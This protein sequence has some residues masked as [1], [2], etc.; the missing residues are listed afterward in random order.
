MDLWP[1][2]VRWWWD[3]LTNPDLSGG[4]E[5]SITR[6]V[7]ATG[8]WMNDCGILEYIEVKEAFVGKGQVLTSDF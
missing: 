6:E 8:V 7:T 3:S 4:V 5:M 2:Q 1:L